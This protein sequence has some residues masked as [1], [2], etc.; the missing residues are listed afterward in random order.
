MFT[1]TLK[2]LLLASLAWGCV[3]ARAANALRGESSAFL[4]SFADS[5]VNWVPW[6]D[7]AIER[8]RTEKRPVFLFVGSFT[9]E[10]SSS[11][12]RQSFANPKSAD[13][14][15]KN[16]ICVLVDR[17]ERPDVAA[18][19]QAY[20]GGLKQ[21]NGWPLNVWL[22]PDFQPYEGAT[23]LSPSEDWGAPG[24]LKLAN[25]ALAAWTTNPAACRRRS[26][27][28]I[29]QLRPLPQAAPPAW[30]LERSRSR[31]AADA[32]AWRSTYDPAL[33]GFGDVPKS[34]EPELIRFM[35]LQSPDDKD[36]ALRTLR[37]LAAS[38]VRDPLDG[39]FFRHAADGAWRIPYQQ[40]TLSDQARIALAFLAGAEG[41]DARSFAQCARGALDYALSRLSRPDGT[42]ASAEDATGDEFSGYYAWTE[43][44]I[45]KVLGADSA[46]FKADHGVLPAGNVPAGDDPSALFAGK[47][48]LRSADV[49]GPGQAAS[50]TLLLAVRD[51]RPSPPRDDRATAGAH[52]LF[53]N[54]LSRAGAQLDEPR[55]L[56]AARRIL[57]AVRR[58]FLMGK[59]GE[60]RR[61]AGSDLPA[62]A[63]DYAALALGAGGFS[64]ASKD[65]AAGELSSRLLAQLDA[66]FLDPAGGTYFGAAEARPG[67]FFIRPPAA[68]DPPTA[69]SLALLARSPNAMAV[70]AALLGGLDDS[71]PQAPGDQLLALR[72][73]ESREGRN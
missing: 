26:S 73:V 60:L 51:R 20:V 16:F 49:A 48:L 41:P 9:S 8:A 57:E 39:G 33:G 13:W 63:D 21:M 15:N 43:A 30:S 62:S 27:D 6:G 58:N 37:A 55:Y 59:D 36:A 72:I 71:G 45:D 1:K 10:L 44:E 34:P 11:M 70:A 42:L 67:V 17:D 23:Y 18:L 56:E 28:S 53:I 7:A 47:N 65:A 19:Y 12:R 50:A 46:S 32:A 2:T 5:P 22:T 64:R 68:G 3:E 14:L 40:K 25:E 61:M 38:A 4:R 31:L 35:L 24:F 69:D 54:A 29:A 52:G 66:R